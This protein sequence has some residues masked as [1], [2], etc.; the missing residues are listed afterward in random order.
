MERR[1]TACREAHA[2]V[3]LKSYPEFLGGR[4]TSES[5]DNGT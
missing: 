3:L 4:E 5:I 1:V 2:V